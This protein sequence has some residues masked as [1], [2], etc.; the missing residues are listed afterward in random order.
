MCN[1]VSWIQFE[2]EEYFITNSD[3]D[4]KEGKKL[5]APDVID[6]LCGH[7]AI[8]SFYPELKTKGT[9]KECEDFNSQ[10]NFPVSIA[11]AIKKGQLGRI[12]ICEKVLNAEGLRRY[13]KIK[14]PA[15]A[16]CNK[17]AVQAWAEYNKIAAQA[18]IKIVS[19]KM[20]R[21]KDWK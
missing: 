20:F 15:L 4:S 14:D 12:G 5:L 1:F 10:G 17:I 2:G 11:T 16:E 19:Q 21:N 6:D 3:L 7:G 13:N 9:K 8:L 18:F